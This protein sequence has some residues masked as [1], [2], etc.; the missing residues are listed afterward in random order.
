VGSKTKKAYNIV[1]GKLGKR[2]HGR[3]TLGWEDNVQMDL[4]DR[5]MD[6]NIGQAFVTTVMNLRDD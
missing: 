5:E 2:P 1:I 4:E 3:Q 6:Q